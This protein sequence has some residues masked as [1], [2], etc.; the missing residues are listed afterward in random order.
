MRAHEKEQKVKGENELQKMLNE[1]YF[2]RIEHHRAILLQP[3]FAAKYGLSGALW[4]D[5]KDLPDLPRG[6]YD[7]ITKKEY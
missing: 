6:L 3:Q 7:D 4:I 5:E 2:Y 1:C